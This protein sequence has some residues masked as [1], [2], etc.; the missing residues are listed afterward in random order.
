MAEP[1]LLLRPEGSRDRDGPIQPDI[2]PAV[3]VIAGQYGDAWYT[4]DGGFVMYDIP[5][6]PGLGGTVL[7]RG[8]MPAYPVSGGVQLLA[9]IGASLA[10]GV[11]ALNGT[12]LVTEF[13]G[14]NI[15]S[16]M[17]T[18]GANWHVHAATFGGTV[19]HQF[20]NGE[21]LASDAYQEESGPGTLYLGIPQRSRSYD[22]ESLVIFDEVLSDED[23]HYI[24]TMPEAWTW[25]N[26]QGTT[27]RETYRAM[28]VG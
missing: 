22:V 3:E 9:L 19:A 23:I 15:F 16:P 18:S 27:Q 28:I 4:G 14:G 25:E 26:L 6:W 17:P 11:M 5:S 8:R 13:G 2:D 1:L 24:S 21:L 7:G 20:L 12:D 10:N